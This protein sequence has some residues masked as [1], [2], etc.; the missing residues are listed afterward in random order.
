V[1]AKV[2]MRVSSADAQ[3]HFSRAPWCPRTH[4]E[5]DSG[6]IPNRRVCGTVLDQIGDPQ[7]ILPSV[8]ELLIGADNALLPGTRAPDRISTDLAPV[9]G[10]GVSYRP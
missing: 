7:R 8:P 9:C 1:L 5:A 10:R 2:R 3:R 6:R 4:N